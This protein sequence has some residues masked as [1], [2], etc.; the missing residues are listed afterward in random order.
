MRIRKTSQYME[1][2][3]GLPSYFTDEIDTGMKWI[4]GKPIYRK[5]IETTT[6]L[7][8]GQTS[9]SHGISNFGQITNWILTNDR[10]QTFPRVETDTTN[11]NWTG[12][13]GVDDT[14]VVI[15]VVGTTWSSRKWIIVIEYTKT[16][17]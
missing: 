14:N 6:A 10:N 12:I 16:T 13:S 1:G 7:S 17:D 15:R 2:G 8:E 4:D 11:N 9:I 5:V 3:V